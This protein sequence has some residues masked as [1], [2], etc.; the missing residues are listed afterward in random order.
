MTEVIISCDGD[1]R[2]ALRQK[3]PEAK[4]QTPDPP[5]K[6]NEPQSP[7]T[8]EDDIATTNE[9]P[10][11]KPE[12]DV[13]VLITASS[14]ILCIASPI[15]KT[16]LTGAFR[17]ASDF[18][19][20]KTSTS[21]TTSSSHEKFTLD[22]PE[23]DPEAFTLLLRILHY[24]YASVPERPTPES[25]EGLAFLCDKYQCTHVLRYCG[26]LWARDWL[27]ACAVA[28]AGVGKEGGTVVMGDAARVLVF[29]YV[30][31]LE[32]EFVDVAWR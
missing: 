16:M 4:P 19:A 23:D 18:A 6:E 14:Q 2:L 27:D 26:R 21:S 13:K 15:F 29:A 20:H 10:Q 12:P 32:R 22:L 5:E 24:D 3:Q 11:T 31:D 17:E 1:I 9:P 30:A 25:L 28:G 7:P 8:H